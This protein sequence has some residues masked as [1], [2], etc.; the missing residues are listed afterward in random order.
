MR[1]LKIVLWSFVGLV[2]TLAIVAAIFV[3]TFDVN[4][5][6]DEIVA[7]AEGETGRKIAINGPI[8]LSFRPLPAIVLRDVTFANASW[9]SQ[10]LML[11][12]AEISAAAPLKALWSSDFALSSF[13]IKDA[14]ILLETNAQG[15]GNW[16]FA[17]ASSQPQQQ[18]APQ[19]EQQTQGNNPPRSLA[20]LRNSFALPDARLENVKLRY[21]DGRTGKVEALDIASL[22]AGIDPIAIRFDI[23]ALYNSARLA[24][25]GLVGA[26]ALSSGRRAPLEL[27]LRLADAR[28][29]ANGEMGGGGREAMMINARVSFTGDNL[30]NLNAFAGGGL[31]QSK[32]FDFKG[33]VTSESANRMRIE[34]LQLVL[35]DSRIEGMLDINR[36]GARPKI[37][38]K[39]RSDRLRE[40]DMPGREAASA[41]A[42][43][44]TPA[45]GTPAAGTPSPTGGRARDDGRLIPSIAIP[46]DGLR[47]W[48]ADL[49]L[50]L[51]RV[52]AGGQSYGPIETKLTLQ[53]AVLALRGLALPVWGSLLKGDISLDARSTPILAA[54]GRLADFD[55]A[56]MLKGKGESPVT[57]KANLS[58]DLRGQGANLR[59]VAANLNG[60]AE[61]IHQDGRINRAYADILAADLF[62]ILGGRGSTTNLNCVIA[63]FDLRDGVATPTMLVADTPKMFAIGAGRI[64]L[65]EERIDMLVRPQ[66]KEAA[67]VNLAV[68]IRLTGY[69]AN[70]VAR[71]DPEGL[72]R[73]IVGALGE[74]VRNPLSLLGPLLSPGVANKDLCRD[75]L[76]GKLPEQTRQPGVA[77]P[78]RLQQ[79]IDQGIRRLFGQ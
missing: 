61:L 16:D 5:Y 33:Q 42:A 76:A 27:D 29:E 15:V 43:R 10:P 59:T 19:P 50:A 1:I 51:Q 37:S 40:E 7:W 48:D 9:G 62:A 17:P 14:E 31:P 28:L 2:A 24:G 66:A 57:G 41:P 39:L 35:G 25:H 20:E 73:S 55:L 12:A 32:P 23:D 22:R 49:D 13:V 8:D 18:T 11:K 54:S 26:E 65:G 53:N 4:R 70:P 52:D 38:G 46:T 69:L 71:P 44:Q 63:R 30:A 36:A 77:V 68:P 75:A 67:M 3:A 79:R 78:E 6:K 34:D 45:A 21:R 74:G 72:A 58:F 60:S 64:L 56:Q 47:K